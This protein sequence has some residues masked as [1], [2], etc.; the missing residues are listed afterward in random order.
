MGPTLRNSFLV[1]SIVSFSF[2]LLHSL[3]PSPFSLSISYA[4]CVWDFR[5]TLPAPPT[6]SLTCKILCFLHK[7]SNF[8]FQI[9]AKDYTANFSLCLGFIWRSQAA[10]FVPL[11]CF[12]SKLPISFPT[13]S[14]SLFLLCVC[15]SAENGRFFFKK[16]CFFTFH[17]WSW[18]SWQI[19]SR[20]YCG[21]L[22]FWLMNLSELVDHFLHFKYFVG[23]CVF[24]SYGASWILINFPV[25][26]W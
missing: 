10:I 20:I 4:S 7:L 23:L 19:S 18:S 15:L 8:S 1:N 2:I 12:N 26:R 11:D 24:L 21:N 25:I 5:W 3:T 14:F 9:H 17:V 22:G 16:F 13:I 6:S